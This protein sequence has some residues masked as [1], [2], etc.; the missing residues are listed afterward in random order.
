MKET[1]ATAFKVYV[2]AIDFRVV[3]LAIVGVV[4]ARCGC[5]FASTFWPRVFV[6][7]ARSFAPAP[8]GAKQR[9]ELHVFFEIEFT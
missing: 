7:F 9:S 2:C 3:L 8:D 6:S 4:S 5:S 1:C